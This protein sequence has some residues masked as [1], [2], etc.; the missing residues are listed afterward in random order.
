M[1]EQRLGPSNTL[2]PERYS[3]T[4]AFWHSRKHIFRGQYFEKYLSRQGDP[5]FQNV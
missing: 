1:F 2:T 5:F 4:G 3:K